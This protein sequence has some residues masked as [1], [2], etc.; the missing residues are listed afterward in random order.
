[1]F[2]SLVRIGDEN[3]ILKDLSQEHRKMIHGAFYGAIREITGKEPDQLDMA[4][5]AGIESF[6]HMNYVNYVYKKQVILKVFMP[7][8]K[9]VDGKTIVN[10][11]VL[12]VWKTNARHRRN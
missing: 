5:H 4:K 11:Q 10:Q 7:T 6:E 3:Q 2:E 1:M 12:E 8:V 9:N